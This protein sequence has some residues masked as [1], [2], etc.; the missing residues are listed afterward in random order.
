MVLKHVQI[1]APKVKDKLFLFQSFAISKRWR[2]AFT[3][4]VLR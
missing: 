3:N 4:E 1:P 2:K